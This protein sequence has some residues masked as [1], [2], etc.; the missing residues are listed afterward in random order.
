MRFIFF[1]LFMDRLFGRSRRV[2]AKLDRILIAQEI[3]MGQLEDLT[4]ALDAETNAVAAKLDKLSAELASAITT[5][6]APKPETLAALSAISDRL[7]SLGAD[8]EAP[9]PAPVPEPAP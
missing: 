4:S 6:Q 7:Q 1:H 9:I 3:I 5:G 2:E 8:P